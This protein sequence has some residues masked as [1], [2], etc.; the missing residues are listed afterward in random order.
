MK[1]KKEVQ[2]RLKYYE[3][4][5]KEEGKGTYSFYNLKECMGHIAL[6]K[7]LKHYT[8]KKKVRIFLE[9]EMKKKAESL[10]THKANL[11]GWG[12]GMEIHEFLWVLEKKVGD[13]FDQNDN[14]RVSNT[15]KKK[16]ERKKKKERQLQ[17]VILSNKPR[18]DLPYPENKVLLSGLN[19]EIKETYLHEKIHENIYRLFRITSRIVIMCFIYNDYILVK[20]FCMS[21]HKKRTF[22]YYFCQFLHFVFDFVS[23]FDPIEHLLSYW[24][25]LHWAQCTE[26][27]IKQEIRKDAMVG[28]RFLRDKYNSG[29]DFEVY[30]IL[31]KIIFYI[32]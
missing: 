26:F 20:S 24:D 31:D 17:Y 5:Q 19:K 11:R 32:E 6:E 4:F 7:V 29:D 25:N 27:D 9:S 14:F 21:L 2:K 8:S 28:K 15:L 3:S 16:E 30:L 23:Y 12:D 18:K 10:K 1:S 13:Y 22:G